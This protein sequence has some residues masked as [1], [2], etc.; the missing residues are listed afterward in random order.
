MGRWILLHAGVDP[1]SATDIGP[2]SHKFCSLVFSVFA[3]SFQTA[4][5][6]SVIVGV[7][8]Q[9]WILGHGYIYV[10]LHKFLSSLDHHG[11]ETRATCVK[12]TEKLRSREGRERP[13]ATRERRREKG[14]LARARWLW[15]ATG[16]GGRLSDLSTSVLI[17]GVW[18]ELGRAVVPIRRK[19]RED[20]VHRWIL[21]NG[22]DLT[23]GIL[24]RV[25]DLGRVVEIGWCRLDPCALNPDCRTKSGRLW[26]R[27]LSSSNPGS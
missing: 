5:N 23:A 18:A 1:T 20:C 27:T 13:R 14:R 26:V 17:F 11:D 10:R 21:T 25:I 19:V 3:S 12:Q 16:S 22:R 8:S 6:L 4:T 7:R 9:D 15:Q 24:L 2:A